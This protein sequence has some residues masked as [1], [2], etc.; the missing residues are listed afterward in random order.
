MAAAR[1]QHLGEHQWHTRAKGWAKNNKDNANDHL[2]QLC[3]YYTHT[4]RVYQKD[5]KRKCRQRI[6]PKRSSSLIDVAFIPS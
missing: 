1:G 4:R 5:G 2:V 3:L 6:S